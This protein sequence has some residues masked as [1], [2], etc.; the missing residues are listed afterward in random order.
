MRLC[1]EATVAQGG[2]L[3][4]ISKIK[5]LETLADATI[6]AGLPLTEE[7]SHNFDQFFE[8]CH[9]FSPTII[10]NNPKFLS[11]LQRHAAINPDHSLT[12]NLE[13]IPKQKI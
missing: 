1:F 4:F 12:G 13:A 7:R 3:K 8:L 9:Y 2:D 11:L 6:K 5:K 10:T